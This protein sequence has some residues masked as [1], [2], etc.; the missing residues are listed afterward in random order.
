MQNNKKDKEKSKGLF[1]KVFKKKDKRKEMPVILLRNS[2]KAEIKYVKP[3]HGQYEIDNAT[4]HERP[5]SDWELKDGLKT[6]KIKII[7]EWGMYP[8]G[9][10]DY[11]QALHN[12]EAAVQY[13]IVRAIQTA[14]TVRSQMEK[15]K[16]KINPKVAI[17]IL[18]GL[19]V[20]AYFL[21]GG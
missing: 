5:G 16:Q 12:E 18:I 3:D 17:L 9:N 21:M 7:P 19:V 4:Y 14:E 20:G 1:S 11:L 15:G 8:L 10:E 6:K 13:D 2:G